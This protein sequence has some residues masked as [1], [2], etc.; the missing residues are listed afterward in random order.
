MNFVYTGVLLPLPGWELTQ[1]RPRV[2][3]LLITPKGWSFRPQ[4]VCLQSIWIMLCVLVP[5]SLDNKGF[6]RFFWMS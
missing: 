5:R 2:Q 6:E 3:V 1:F 4:V